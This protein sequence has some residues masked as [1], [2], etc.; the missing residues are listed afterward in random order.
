[1][2]RLV[3]VVSVEVVG[4][5]EEGALRGANVD[6]PA[7]KRKM[8]AAAIEV[9]GWALGPGGP[10][11]AIEIAHEHTVLGR[12][13][14]QPREDLG[15]AFPEVEEAAMAGFELALDGSGLP[16]EAELE[17]RARVAGTATPFG[18]LRLRRCWRGALGP[19]PPLISIVVVDGSEDEEGLERT[20][21]SLR[22]QRHPFTE[23]LVLRESPLNGPSLHN[24]GIRR[25]NGELILFCEAGSALASDALALALEMLVRQPE[26]SAVVDGDEEEIAAAVYRRSAFEELGGFREDQSGAGDVELAQRA[27]EY[28][29]IFAPGALVGRGT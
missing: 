15:Q 14:P 8:A 21:A 29:A 11:E 18:R 17:L 4:F 12:A 20:L 23:V 13:V 16:A 2:G 24:E 1:M 5:G 25:S 10:A 19:E 26:A 27:L 22:P 3:E 6:S 9:G 7:P 28:D